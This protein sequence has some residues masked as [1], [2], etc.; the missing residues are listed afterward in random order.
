MF[1]HELSHTA[2]AAMPLHIAGLVTKELGEPS[3]RN[4]HDAAWYADAHIDFPDGKTADCPFALR[5]DRNGNASLTVPWEQ[6][7]L[8]S[9]AIASLV[10][11]IYIEP[12]PRGMRR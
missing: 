11:D 10:P 4:G 3:F 1:A 12:V 9:D 6:Q 5:I 2:T 8:M 7:Q